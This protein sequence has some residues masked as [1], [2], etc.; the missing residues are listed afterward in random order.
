MAVEAPELFGGELS[1]LPAEPDAAALAYLYVRER[2][3]AAIKRYAGSPSER[4]RLCGARRALARSVAATWDLTSSSPPEFRRE[5]E[6]WIV[7]DG[8]PLLHTYLVEFQQVAAMSL[9]CHASLRHVV[10]VPE[11]ELEFRRERGPDAVVRLLLRQGIHGAL[12]AAAGACPAA[13]RR[14]GAA[15]VDEACVEALALAGLDLLNG[16]RPDL[17]GCVADASVAGPFVPAQRLV[18]MLARRRLH[19]VA[20][21]GVENLCSPRLN[22]QQS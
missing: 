10:L 15:L 14:P 7:S 9:C 13:Y 8:C 12:A 1:P 18:A 17:S 19:V 21:I 4:R 11:A 3:P 5:S 20:Q 6:V 2:R 22:V 16:V